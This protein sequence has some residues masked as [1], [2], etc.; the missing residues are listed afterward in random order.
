MHMKLRPVDDSKF[1]FIR[2]DKAFNR[3]L[4]MFKAQYNAH[5]EEFGRKIPLR[6]PPNKMFKGKGGK[7]QGSRGG[8][9]TNYIS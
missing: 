9:D 4:V 8:N 7:N 6:P 1:K 2:F 3:K 5:E